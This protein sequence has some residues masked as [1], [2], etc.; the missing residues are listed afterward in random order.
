MMDPPRPPEEDPD[1]MYK[2]PLLP[3]LAVPELNTSK[4]L[5]P[6]VPAFAVR[7]LRAPL[8][9]VE[10][11]P[12]ATIKPPPVATVLSP[13]KSFN[14]PPDPLDP[15]PTAT[16]M[17]PPRPPDDNPDP[18][19]KAPLL[20]LLAVPELNT[21]RPLTPLVPALAVRILKAPL[22][23]LEPAPV[24]MIKPPP[25]TSVLSPPYILTPPPDPLDPLP[26]ASR[27]DPP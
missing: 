25:V 22:L 9:D 17:E 20:P 16:K 13:A 8:L 26:T 15:L 24:A 12:V 18:M 11:E 14:P 1:P 19:Y 27:I 7:S 21:N 2:D 23:D 3:R 5:T 6:L 10:P 4:P